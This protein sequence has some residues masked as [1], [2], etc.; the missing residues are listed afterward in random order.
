MN[1][2]DLDDCFFDE[3]LCF[4]FD[5]WLVVENMIYCGE[6]YICFFGNIVNSWLYGFFLKYKIVLVFFV[7]YVFSRILRYV[8]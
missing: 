7:R 3:C 1:I 6:V 2:V 8:N 5:I 4:C